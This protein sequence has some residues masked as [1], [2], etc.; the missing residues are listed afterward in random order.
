MSTDSPCKN[1]CR[2]KDEYCVACK[3]HIDEI[4]EWYNMTESQKQAVI[5]RIKNG[6]TNK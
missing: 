1:V 4:V 2:L 5:K 6:T 3:R